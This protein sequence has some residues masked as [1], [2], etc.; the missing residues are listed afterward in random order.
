MRIFLVIPIF[1]ICHFSYAQKLIPRVGISL[2]KTSWDASD[3]EYHYKGI[4]PRA[5]FLIGVGYEL[6]ITG[7]FNFQTELTYVQKGQRTT[8]ESRNPTIFYVDNRNYSL[9]FLENP[10]L[11]NARFGNGKVK[12][13]PHFGWT[14]GFGLGGKMGQYLAARSS[15]TAKLDEYPVDFDVNFKKEV[16]HSKGR[17]IF[18]GRPLDVGIQSGMGI[19][20]FDRLTV[21]VRYTYGL[22]GFR[23]FR[24]EEDGNRV[25]QFSVSTPILLKDN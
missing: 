1:V 3:T 23:Y 20:L 11:I 12:F 16:S 10:I 19:L 4:Q 14:V 17:E 18:V 5:G 13:F 24:N 2:S 8:M 9:S 7:I 22:V 21:D 25:L 15:P 6:P